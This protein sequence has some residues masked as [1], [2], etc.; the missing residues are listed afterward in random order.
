MA[1]LM[2]RV[3]PGNLEPSAAPQLISAHVK[4][5]SSPN[6]GSDGGCHACWFLG[7]AVFSADG[8]IPGGGRGDHSHVSFGVDLIRRDL[9]LPADAVSGAWPRKALRQ[10]AKAALGPA[11]WLQ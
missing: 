7:Q 1:L 5:K 9:S 8:D 2:R 10:I 4:V 3:Q 11:P 6:P